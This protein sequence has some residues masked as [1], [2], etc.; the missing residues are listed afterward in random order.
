MAYMCCIILVCFKHNSQHTTRAD[1]SLH[2][3]QCD[4][5]G[6][7]IALWAAFKSL[8]QQ[9]Y[10]PN[11]TYS[12]AIIENVSKS[13]IFLVKSFLGNFYR[14]LAIFYGHTDPFLLKSSMLRP[15]VRNGTQGEGETNMIWVIQVSARHILDLIG[16]TDLTLSRMTKILLLH[17]HTKVPPGLN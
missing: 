1:M 4:Q 15:S 13:L 16:S 7:F 11:L 3:S 12:W 2:P 9:I 17:L 14:N 6:R 8:W 10:C 5:I